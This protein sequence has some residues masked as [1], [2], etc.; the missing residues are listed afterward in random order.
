VDTESEKVGVAR[1]GERGEGDDDNRVKEGCLEWKDGMWDAFSKALR[2]EK[3]EGRDAGDFVVSELE[4]HPG[5]NVY[6][7]LRVRPGAL[8]FECRVE[9]GLSVGF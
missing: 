5:E 9:Q 2:I 7:F 8:Y 1:I 4:Y 6:S 3:G